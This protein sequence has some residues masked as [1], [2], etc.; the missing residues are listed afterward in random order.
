M[1]SVD[2]EVGDLA[3]LADPELD[4]LPVALV[5]P[6]PSRQV[7]VV[8]EV[9]EPVLEPNAAAV[10][11][12]PAV[13]PV[14]VSGVFPQGHVLVPVVATRTADEISGLNRVSA[15]VA[16]LGQEREVQLLLPGLGLRRR[17]ELPGSIVTKVT[18][19]PVR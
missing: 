11:L 9:E 12:Q 18:M 10:L 5:E 8:V 7:V 17:Q 16:R 4:H 1:L 2:R 6:E 15:R 14:R 19:E 13:H 3:A